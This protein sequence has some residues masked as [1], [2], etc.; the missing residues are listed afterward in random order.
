VRSADLYESLVDTQT[1]DCIVVPG[2]S[3]YWMIRVENRV[4]GAHRLACERAHGPAPT[5]AHEARHLTCGVSR[6]FNPRH[7]VWGTHSE[8]EMDKHE[9]GTAFR[10]ERVNTARLTEDD[11]RDI[12]RRLEAGEG[13]KPLAR[14]FRVAPATIRQIANGSSWAWLT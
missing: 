8:N 12:R 1:D 4:V 10:G 6:C 14:A 2:Q 7:L 3:R 13:K 5:E 9:H 11:V